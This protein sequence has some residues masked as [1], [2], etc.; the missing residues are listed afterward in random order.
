LS[1]AWEVVP[2]HRVNPKFWHFVNDHDQVVAE[3]LAKYFVLHGGFRLAKKRIA[4]LSLNHFVGRY[5]VDG[6][7]IYIDWQGFLSTRTGEGEAQRNL[8]ASALGC[9]VG[10][11]H[12]HVPL[13]GKK[14]LGEIHLG[15]RSSESIYGVLPRR[16]IY[17]SRCHR[18]IDCAQSLLPPSA[19]SA[20]HLFNPKPNNGIYF[21]RWP[22]RDAHLYGPQDTR[23]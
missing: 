2:K 11:L 23:E 20:R 7:I 19:H 15:T 16:H 3:H 22:P 4:K 5:H 18:P 8:G 1:G 6:D 17:R 12:S 21:C 9:W 10:H 13:Y 14:V